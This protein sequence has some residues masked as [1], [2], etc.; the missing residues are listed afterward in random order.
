MTTSHIFDTYAKTSK[1]KITHFDVA[2]DVKDADKA[3]AYSL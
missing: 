1:G 3:L 2:L